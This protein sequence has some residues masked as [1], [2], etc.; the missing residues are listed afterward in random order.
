MMSWAL[1][2]SFMHVAC[3]LHSPPL[4]L[5]SRLQISSWKQLLRQFLLQYRVKIILF[6]PIISLL[7]CC[8]VIFL[9]FPWKHPNT[10]DCVT[11]RWYPCVVAPSSTGRV[12]C[13]YNTYSTSVGISLS[14]M[15]NGTFGARGPAPT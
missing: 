13:A 2:V 4:L 1:F 15:K 7:C 5:Q 3:H 6:Q 9:K 12:L 8:Y 10:P 11:G 14:Q